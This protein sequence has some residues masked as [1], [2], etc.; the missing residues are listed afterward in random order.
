MAAK[1]N[2]WSFKPYQPPPVPTG[3]YDPALDAQY[4][5]AQRGFQYSSQD[6]Q[7]NQ[8]RLSS[9]YGIQQ[10]DIGRSWQ[11][12]NE[13]M[14]LSFRYGQE[15]VG[16]QR[17]RGYSD[18]DLAR[19]RGGEDYNRAVG[20][21]TR[22]YDR[23]AGQQQE[24]QVRAGGLLRSGAAL[25]AAQKRS[26]NMAWD[27]API[28]TN[29]N[30]FL[31]DNTTSRTRLGEDTSRA[32]QRQRE[33]LFIGTARAGE[34]RDSALA[35]AA[36]GFERGSTDI[37]TGSWRAGQEQQQFGLDVEAQKQF[38]AAQAG[39]VA[40]QRGEPGGPPTNEFTS[41][42]G[43]PYRVILRN[44]QRIYV[45]RTGRRLQGRPG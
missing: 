5:A 31:A 8:L 7:Q 6:A 25:Q 41:P 10:G 15:D 36:L 19:S 40:P 28:D 12:G 39:Y 3:S 29:Y 13:D 44:G 18:L 26:E 22:N 20:Q 23:L 42:S 27:K 17:D 1:K 37:N 30:R 43:T 9:D 21:L 32:D 35:R 38:Q 4:R 16:T 34:D 2:P 24:Q 14:N 11:R 45:D 33:A